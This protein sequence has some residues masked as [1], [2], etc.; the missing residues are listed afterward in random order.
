MSAR[1]PRSLRGLPVAAALLVLFGVACSCGAAP[2]TEALVAVPSSVDEAEALH[3][4]PAVE[5]VVVREARPAGG[6]CGHSPVC[7]VLLPILA[8]QA[9]F[10]PEVDVVD[11][12]ESGG[13][14][15]HG[16]YQPG[17]DLIWAERTDGTTL[18]GARLLELPALGRRLV[19][20]SGRGEVG[21][22]GVAGPLEPVGVLSQ[23]DLHGAYEAA[24]AAEDDADTRAELLVEAVDALH[25][26]SGPLVEAWLR[27]PTEGPA[28]A[29]VLSRVCLGARFDDA[30]PLRADVLRWSAAATPVDIAADAL[31][32]AA[33]TP[34]LQPEEVDI[35]AGV[36]VD[37]VCAHPTLTPLAELSDAMQQEPSL[38]PRAV[39]V[40]GRCTTPTRV[41]LL[42]A[43][44]G[45]TLPPDALQ[46]A[47]HDEPA[48]DLLLAALRPDRPADRLALFAALDVAP[49]LGPVTEAL[50][51]DP[52]L[53]PTR[54]EAAALLRAYFAYEPS[55]LGRRDP[56][57]SALRLLARTGS[58][59]RAPLLLS[60]P[61]P[62]G[63]DEA[64]EVAAA[65]LVLGD[66]AGAALLVDRRDL[67]ACE[68]SSMVVG[69][70]G[71]A[72]EALQAAGCTCEDLDAILLGRPVGT[73]C[74]VPA[75]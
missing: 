68:G 75:P 38:R 3:D 65:R 32:C 4:P 14:R 26:E 34:A 28:R 20:A 21:A 2:T 57:A 54:N 39:L 70:A 71:L 10:P 69:V 16:E 12:R 49:T 15:V 56:Q 45:E 29:R 18:V 55:F 40:A 63:D 60:L 11:I 25:A 27:R 1:P 46:A 36:L 44:L 23:V 17:G 58:A 52:A 74:P 48:R 31:V 9:V 33:R 35:F 43:Y 22:D 41:T 67:A 59:D 61:A 6:A 47:L 19:V 30:D 73:T 62:A 13:G 37:D 7:L 53:V 72:S 5:V 66:R 51:A 64:L 50:A 24:L 42:R 8:W